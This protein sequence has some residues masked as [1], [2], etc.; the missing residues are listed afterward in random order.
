MIALLETH[1][2]AIPG[3]LQA[4]IRRCNYICL[5]LPARKTHSA[6]RASGGSLVLIR[7]SFEIS[8]IFKEYFEWGELTQLVIEKQY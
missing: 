7:K 1:A 8:G 2:L 4:H 5:E 6:G 3:D